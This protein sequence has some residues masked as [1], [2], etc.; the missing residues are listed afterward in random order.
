MSGLVVLPA[1]ARIWSS[2]DSVHAMDRRWEEDERKPAVEGLAAEMVKELAPNSIIDLGCGS[3][4]YADVF[5]GWNTYIGVDASPYMIEL[6]QDRVRKYRDD[7]TELYEADVLEWKTRQRPDLITCLHLSQHFEHPLEFLGV[8]LE[9]YYAKFYLITFVTH[10]RQPGDVVD[11]KIGWEG[12]EDG[13]N[14]AAR[15]IHE[16]S[17]NDFLSGYDVVDLRKAPNPWHEDANY[18]FALIKA[19]QD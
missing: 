5:E 1:A 10:D 3:A 9:R 11:F 2:E 12:D 7:R 19:W 13:S 17:M 4:R 14:I 15:S 6:A 18:W 8:I 16:S